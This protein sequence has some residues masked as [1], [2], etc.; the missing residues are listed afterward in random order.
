MSAVGPA[1]IC[2]LL[3]SL[4]KHSSLLPDR[5]Q[6]CDC[7]LSTISAADPWIYESAH[8]QG[9]CTL[10]RALQVWPYRTPWCRSEASSFPQMKADTWFSKSGS[11]SWCAGGK[12]NQLKSLLAHKLCYWILWCVNQLVDSIVFASEPCSVRHHVSHFLSEEPPSAGD[13]TPVFGGSTLWSGASQIVS[14][15]MCFFPYTSR[16]TLRPTQIEVQSRR[17]KCFHFSFFSFLLGF[18]S[19]FH[20]R[21]SD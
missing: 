18:L 1:D 17:H 21:C 16:E 10:S 20:F 12:T 5:R 13:K 2:L 9:F 19:L 7:I 15:V 8:F 4:L 3:S 6:S 11:S 14:T